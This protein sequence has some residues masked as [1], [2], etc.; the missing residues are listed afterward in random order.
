MAHEIAQ[1]FSQTGGGGG[2]DTSSDACLKD[3]GGNAFHAGVA[4][5]AIVLALVGLADIRFYFL[6]SF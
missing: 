6:I 1:H 2:G 4:L 3:L 5:L